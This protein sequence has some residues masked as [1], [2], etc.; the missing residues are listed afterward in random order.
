MARQLGLLMATLVLREI[1]ER[2]VEALSV[3]AKANSR[4]V[5]AEAGAILTQEIAR[6]RAGLGKWEAALR[7]AEMTPN[8]ISQTDSV[9]MLREDRDG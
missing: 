2:T 6:A 9:K 8:G 1:D 3:R 7:I 5:E 4:S